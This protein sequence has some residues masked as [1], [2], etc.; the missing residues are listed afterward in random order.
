MRLRYLYRLLALLAAIIG[1]LSFGAYAIYSFYFYYQEK[2]EAG[3]L[4]PAF[5]IMPQQARLLVIAPHC[6]DET[7]GCAGVIQEVINA[8]GQVMVVSM[9]NGDGFTLAVEEQY[10]RFFLTSEDYIKSGYAR[11]QEL[12][13]ALQ[14]LGVAENRV[15]FLGYPDRGLKAL[16]TDHWD[17]AQPYPS[18]YTGRDHSP[19]SNSF[20]LNAPYA[21]EAVVND[22]AAIL[23]EYQPTMILSPHPADEHP[24]HAATWSF[25]AAAVAKSFYS[26]A[27]PKPKIYAYLVHRGDFPLPHGYRPESMLLPP[28]PLYH[29]AANRWQAYAL[30]KEQETVKELALNEYASQ[31]RVPVMSS[32]L[33]SFIRKNE[34]FEEVVIPV[35][36]AQSVDA[37]LAELDSWKNIGPVF[38]YPLGVSALGAI[39]PKAKVD[40]LACVLKDNT[41]WLRLHIPNFALHHHQYQVHIISFR[42]SETTFMRDKESLLFSS[43]TAAGAAAAN[44]MR[45]KDDV[46]IK[47]PYSGQALPDYLLMQIV[48]KDRFSATIQQ[49]SWQQLQI[50]R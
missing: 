35:V 6:D 17:S 50:K 29:T 28:R 5:V 15:L 18:H 42:Q 47:L 14:R 27:L 16:W 33:R 22:L 26:E 40:S 9:T 41:V 21:G 49:T 4:L 19:Y 36:R 24:D 39:E 12:I 43:T 23:A 45:F 34:L 25:V 31:L 8:G 11:Q 37:D 30:T 20:R 48:T 32:L 38:I 1:C 46:I 13:R 2:P 3:D 7:L 44:L 10:R